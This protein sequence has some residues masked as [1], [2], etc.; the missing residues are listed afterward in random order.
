MSATLSPNRSR[1]PHELSVSRRKACKSTPRPIYDTCS[2][3]SSV[4]G[5]ALSVDRRSSHHDLVTRG[6][7]TSQLYLYLPKSECFIQT[8]LNA[9]DRLNKVNE[10][11]YLYEQQQQQLL[12]SPRYAPFA[13][14]I[15]MHSTV[16]HMKTSGRPT[17]SSAIFRTH[18]APISL[19][20][21]FYE[22]CDTVQ[23]QRSV[24]DS[25]RADH[26]RR[27]LVPKLRNASQ[28]AVF[29]LEQ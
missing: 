3:S 2:H 29:A 10:E 12:F 23:I 26:L 11:A 28:L 14:R 17:T 19:K 25:G 27:S 8:Q 13:Q 21:V 22:S 5:P 24:S 4:I 20:C 18:A 7:P 6:L 9:R 15:P 16:S 1:S